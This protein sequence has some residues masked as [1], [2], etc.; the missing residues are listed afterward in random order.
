MA[1]YRLIADGNGKFVVQR[2][3]WLWWVCARFAVSYKHGHVN[4]IGFVGWSDDEP[5]DQHVTKFDESATAVKALL[6][7]QEHDRIEDNKSRWTTVIDTK[8]QKI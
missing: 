8:E 1:R 7:A 2:K 3:E 6:V 4:K 5:N